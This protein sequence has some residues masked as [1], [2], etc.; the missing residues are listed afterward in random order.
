MVHDIL[1]RKEVFPNPNYI[2]GSTDWKTARE[3]VTHTSASL[4]T[5]GLYSFQYGHL[6]V[7]AK[8]SNLTGTWPAIWTLGEA[9]DWPSNGEVDVMENYGGDILAN[10]AWGTQTPWQPT[11]DASHWPVAEFDPD[12]AERFHIWELDWT[13][14]RMVIRLDGVVLNEVALAGTINGS[15]ACEGQNP[16]MQ[17][18]RLLLNLALGGAGGSVEDLSFPTRY[19]IDYVRI[20][21]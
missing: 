14:E 7:R 19:L 8:V 18:H 5:Q 15:A 10:F 13:A 9:C 20:Y 11:W 4:T 3:M 6:V 17:P 1:G 2:E 21:P 12:W 16:F